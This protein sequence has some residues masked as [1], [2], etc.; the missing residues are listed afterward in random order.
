MGGS[1][2]G[3]APPVPKETI[4][5]TEFYGLSYAHLKF[6]YFQQEFELQ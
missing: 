6:F 2:A 4:T 1:A 3:M 5:C